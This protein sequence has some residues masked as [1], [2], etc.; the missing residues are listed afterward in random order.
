MRI[1]YMIREDESNWYF[2]KFSQLLLL[3]CIGTVNKN[4]NFNIRVR[5]VNIFMQMKFIITKKGFALS[6]VWKERVFGTRIWPIVTIRKVTA[7]PFK[8]K[9]CT[10]TSILIGQKR[11]APLIPPNFDLNSCCA[12]WLFMT[13]LLRQYM[14]IIYKSTWCMIGLQVQV[15]V[16]RV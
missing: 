12:L 15:H 13:V 14:S 5:G 2:N 6:L 10:I 16:C 3:N 11:F 1:E 9:M 7:H 8:W 4:L